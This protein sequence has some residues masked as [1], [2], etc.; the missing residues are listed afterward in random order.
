MRTY[1]LDL[2]LPKGWQELDDGQ[3]TLVF[4]LLAQGFPKRAIKKDCRTSNPF[5]PGTPQSILSSVL[6][7]F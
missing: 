2:T 7:M 6:L 1:N 4:R 5:Q 3:L